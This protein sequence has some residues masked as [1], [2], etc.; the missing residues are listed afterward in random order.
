MTLSPALDTV[1]QEVLEHIALFSATDS[2]LG[3][4]SSL[5]PLL[6]TNR[7]VYKR[8]SIHSNHHLYARVFAH[9]FDIGPIVRRLGPERT[10]PDI[11]TSELRRRCFCLK[12]IRARL[13]SI[14]SSAGGEEGDKEEDTS[15][16]ELLFQAYLLM[17]E[18]EGK[19]EQQLREYARIDLWLREYWF[20][21]MGAS[22]AVECLQTE[23]W[24]PDTEERSLA[25]W[26][27]WF[28]LRPSD[29]NKGDQFAWNALDLLKTFALAAH[30]YDLTNPSWDRFL[31]APRYP[32]P[33]PVT[34]YDQPCI[35]SP[36]PLA[37]PAI[38]AFLTLV[39]K[40]AEG[41]GYST[42]LPPSH[43]SAI[44]PIV[45]HQLE[46]ECEWERCLSLGQPEYD[47][48][49]TAAFRP[50]SIEGVWEG[51]FTYTEFTAYAALLAGGL[52]PIIQKS[53]VVRHRQTWKLRE[54]HLL[55]SDPSRS[56]SDS[57]I[58][59]DSDN[60]DPLPA[61]DPLRS[62]FP[63]GT[64]IREK[65]DG[66]EVWVPNS[67]DVLHYQRAPRLNSGVC[68]E[69]RKASVVQDI[70]IT[71]EGHSA[72]GQF[73]LIGRVRPCDGFVSLSKEYVDGDRGKWLYRGY[74]VGNVNGNLAGRWRDT[75][76]P[77][78]MQGYE[79][80]FAMSRRR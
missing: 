3:P 32:Q 10:T 76:T 55:A 29:Y 4:P 31:P 58:E 12:R 59:L 46:W 20:D 38:L 22:C 39:N 60:T 41:V 13:D 63:T 57:G 21:E 37:T 6:L 8:L 44:V 45:R 71:G 64:Q 62:Y 25:M 48:F 65:S 28:L 72:W 52:P 56:D 66:I 1:P 18:N 78:D 74:L 7:G 35:I 27:F 5:V 47:K 54:H 23:E 36:P 33:K 19:N 24:L 73:N 17:L 9:K 70:I 79:G 68:G 16:H 40:L 77:T 26:L 61:G 14:A 80:C 51:L 11:L 53:M 34:Y 2:F 50:G 75:L 49:L 30:K 67:G 42:P 15:R 43:P 69:E